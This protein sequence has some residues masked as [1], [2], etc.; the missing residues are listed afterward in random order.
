MPIMPDATDPCGIFFYTVP[1]TDN[2]DQVVGRMDFVR[3][4]RQSFFGRY[5]IDDFRSP[6]T[7]N[8][9]LL[10]LTT[11]PGN[12][13]RAQSVTLGHIYTFSHSLVNAFHATLNR[14]RDNR[15][16]GRP[17]THFPEEPRSSRAAL[18]G[19]HCRPTCGQCIWNSG[20]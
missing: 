3:S 18:F 5:L 10:L 17:R 11:T 6:A 20:T 8:P 13:E 1:S 15:A 9:H 4:R 16:P 2:E 14:R 19:F 7:F 12:W